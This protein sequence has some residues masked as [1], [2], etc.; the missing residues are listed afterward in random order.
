MTQTKGDLTSGNV[1]KR[2]VGFAL[3]FLFSC[4]MQAFY[5]AVDM[6]T[7]GRFSTTANLA[8]V[9]TGA[10]VT[11]IV[12]G[13]CVGISMGTTV[14]IG[15][16]VGARDR[17]TADQAL[18]NSVWLFAV[19]AVILTPIMIFGSSTITSI[20]QTPEKAVSG[21]VEYIRI[22][23]IGVPFIVA[24]NVISAILRGDGNSRMPMVFIGIA[25]VVNVVG[26]LLLTGL[27]G[28]G[29]VGVAI[30]TVT[31]QAVSS[32]VGILYLCKKGLSFPIT[33][34]GFKLSANSIK[35]IL[36]NGLP[37]AAQDTLIN[38]SF[39]AITVIANTRGITD[40]SAVG[41]VEKLIQLM[42]LFPTAMM[43]ALSAFT[44]Q[45]V[46][47]KKEARAILAVKYGIVI[48]LAFGLLS[49]TLSQFIGEPMASFFSTDAAVI[50]AAAEYLRTYSIDCII[51]AFSFCLNGYF[52]GIDKSI[53]VFI[54]NSISAF[55]VRIPLAMLFS[56][57][58]SES[59]LPMGLASPIGS[60]VSLAICFGYLLWLS[61]KHK[62]HFRRKEGISNES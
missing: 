26:D 36:F 23:G 28:F 41:V 11:Q 42:F 49:C 51:V 2:L 34:N 46:G 27:F 53:I 4:F 52:C 55:G 43:S 17:K 13:F 61:R 60:L 35:R 38:I 19:L 7:I 5:G 25:C 58:F 12:T 39:I 29:V 45:N 21:A 1:L 8:A 18:G 54:H 62:H 10:Q 24:Y 31:A 33:K 50:H 59:M 22:C 56:N 6:W 30:A 47:A 20:M 40:A 16:S 3:P 14:L 48:T 37:I 9:N 57:M 32:I 44:S 15:H